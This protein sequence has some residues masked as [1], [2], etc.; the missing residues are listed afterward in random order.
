M[1]WPQDPETG[2]FWNM[3]QI[4]MKTKGAWFADD[5]LPYAWQ[6]CIPL[7]RCFHRLAELGYQYRWASALE[8]ATEPLLERITNRNKHIKRAKRPST[9]AGYKAVAQRWDSKFGDDYRAGTIPKGWP[10]SYAEVQ[11][12]LLQLQANNSNGGPEAVDAQRPAAAGSKK[13]FQVSFSVYETIIILP[14]FDFIF[15]SN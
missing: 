3:E 13:G 1:F 14:I 12:Y 4:E 8:E 2:R 11:D 15:Y 5:G 9:I 7:L 10:K 6:R